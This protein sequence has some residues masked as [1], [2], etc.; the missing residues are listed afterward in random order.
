MHDPILY[1]INSRA[2]LHELAEHAGHPLTL[3]E[4]PA[5]AI[6]EWQR[7]GFTHVWLMG[8]WTG[9]PLARAQA[10]AAAQTTPGYAEALPG[11]RPDDVIASPYAV[12]AYEVDPAL[13]GETGLQQ[14]RQRLH[15]HGL[16]L[17][18]DF[19][20]N[21]LGLDHPWIRQRPELFVQGAR[22]VAGTFTPTTDGPPWIAHGK[23]PYFPPWSDTAQLDFRRPDTRA[24]MTQA[25]QSVADRCDGVRCDMAML[26]LRDVFERTWAHF[27]APPEAAA[28]EFWAE[29][30]P[31]VRQDRSDFLFLAE[32]YW[33]LEARLRELGFDYTYDKELYDHLVARRPTEAVSHLQ[34]QSPVQFRGG[35]HFLENHDEPRIASLLSWEEHRAAAFVTLCLPGMRFLHQGQL[36]G[37]RVRTPVQLRRHWPELPNASVQAWYKQL[38]ALLRTTAV[39]HGEGHLLAP[40]PAWPGNPT[41]RNFVVVRWQAVPGECYL[42][43]ANLAPHRGQCRVLLPEAVWPARF[44]MVEDVLNQVPN[45]ASSGGWEGPGLVLDLPAQGI[46]LLRVRGNVA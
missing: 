17:V 21:H 20:P 26:V 43:V 37:A 24:A 29:A 41:D 39:G 22:P 28:G 38:L 25:L 33:G 8:V 35:V 9:G 36:T 44:G 7:L 2:W 3:A 27:P 13:G 12:A 15:E 18:L 30:I 14:F 42:A 34:R 4:V 19:I 32:V 46:Q 23:D 45:P 16:K 40:Q 1:E 31:A 11:F 5:G 6:A 10:L